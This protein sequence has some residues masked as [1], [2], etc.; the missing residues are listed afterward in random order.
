M[1]FNYIS[2][3]NI[4]R[5]IS[6]GMFYNSLDGEQ[7]VPEEVLIANCIMAG[8]DES[9]ARNALDEFVEKD[10]YERKDGYYEHI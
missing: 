3:S 7:K 2:M 5:A 10:I 6:K 1:L 9:E 8:F 4:N